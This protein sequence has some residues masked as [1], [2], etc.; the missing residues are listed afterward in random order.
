MDQAECRSRKAGEG[1]ADP[2]G[3]PLADGAPADQGFSVGGG[4]DMRLLDPAVELG[5]GAGVLADGLRAEW[6]LRQ[7]GDP[8]TPMDLRAL[9]TRDVERRSLCNRRLHLEAVSV[10]DGVCGDSI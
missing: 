10:L 7:G 8:R 6:T 5:E 2:G 3:E 4:Q 9:Q 1:L